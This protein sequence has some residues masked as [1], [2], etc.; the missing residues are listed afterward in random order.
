MPLLVESSGIFLFNTLKNKYADMPKRGDMLW[1]PAS[2]FLKNKLIYFEKRHFILLET[3]P[4][5]LQNRTPD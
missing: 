1:K 5:V 4:H 3:A 2:Y